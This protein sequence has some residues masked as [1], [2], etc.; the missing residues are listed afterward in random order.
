M[1][2]LG[3]VSATA[4]GEDGLGPFVMHH[5]TNGHEW[6]V[7]PWGPLLNLPSGW[8]FNLHLGSKVIP[9]DLSISQHIVMMLIGT[10][11]LLVLLIPAARRRKLAPTNK[12]SHVVEAGVVFL[13]DEVLRPSMGEEDAR[14]W[15]PF[16]LTLFFFLLTLNF[17]G[18]IPGFAPATSN[19]NFTAVLAILIF[20]IYNISG[21]RRN[22]PV[23]Y[24]VNVVPKGLP[25]VLLPLMAVMEILALFTRAFA[26]AIRLFANMTAGHLMIVS[27]VGLIAVFKTYWLAPPFVAL[28]FFVYLI[29]ILVAFLQAYI[30]TLLSCVFLGMSLNQEH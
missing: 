18:L 19:L 16:F 6:K 20:F 24:F 7:T 23:H 2:A 9:I 29:E 15:L 11:L 5:V 4:W 26:L 27:M 22:G 30:F 3:L 14:R 1:A 13:R 21:M 17:I 12:F 8:M 10:F 28:T 25:L